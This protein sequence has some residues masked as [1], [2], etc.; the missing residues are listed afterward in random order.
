MCNFEI[1]F[2]SEKKKHL[3]KQQIKQM[4]FCVERIFSLTWF[5][6]LKLEMIRFIQRIYYLKLTQSNEVS[7]GFFPDRNIHP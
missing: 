4:L 7:N 1:W 2:F 6:K 5:S 3:Q